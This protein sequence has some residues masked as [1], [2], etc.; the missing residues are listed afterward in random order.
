MQFVN[1]T[2]FDEMKLL[3]SPF[4]CVIMFAARDC[5]LL[6]CCTEV[7][8]HRRAEEATSRQGSVAAL[9][10]TVTVT[11]PANSRRGDATIHPRQIHAKLSLALSLSGFEIFKD[12]TSASLREYVRMA[13]LG[14]ASAPS[15]LEQL[16]KPRRGN[17]SR[18]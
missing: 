1:R 12:V 2:P 13:P 8:G 4:S 16:F 15:Y 18:V 5:T 10:V 3:Y 7:F 14:F 6:D 17:K 11:F 9:Q